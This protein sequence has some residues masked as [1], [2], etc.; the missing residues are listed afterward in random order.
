VA[1]G[2]TAQTLNRVRF[3]HRR[4]RKVGDARGA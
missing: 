4:G 3:R 1:A 2:N